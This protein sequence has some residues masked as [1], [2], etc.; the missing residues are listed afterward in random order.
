M[1]SLP[2]I[3]LPTIDPYEVASRLCKSRL[4]DGVGPPDSVFASPQDL[5]WHVSAFCRFRALIVRRS[6]GFDWLLQLR[7][8]P[9]FLMQ[10]GRASRRAAHQ[11]FSKEHSAFTPSSTHQP[12]DVS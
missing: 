1:S 12:V 11:G 9:A 5:S 4:L 6:S 7:W 8:L 2:P 10:T 3:F